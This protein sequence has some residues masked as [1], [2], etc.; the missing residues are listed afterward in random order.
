KCDGPRAVAWPCG[1]GPPACCLAAGVGTRTQQR[2][3]TKFADQ[4]DGARAFKLSLRLLRLQNPDRNLLLNCVRT[5]TDSGA[6]I[7]RPVVPENP[8]RCGFAAMTAGPT[9]AIPTRFF[10]GLGL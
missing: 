3:S 5:A 6:R 8:I 2:K 4:N 9:V 7:R 1:E 10:I